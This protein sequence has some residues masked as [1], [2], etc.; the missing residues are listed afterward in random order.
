MWF[1]QFVFCPPCWCRS[2]RHQHG[3]AIHF[4]LKKEFM[5]L[6]ISLQK[7]LF[8][9]QNFLDLWSFTCSL[10]IYTWILLRDVKS[11][12]ILVPRRVTPI[13]KCYT[14]LTKE[15]ELKCQ[16]LCNKNSFWLK[17]WVTKFYALYWVNNIWFHPGHWKFFD[18]VGENQ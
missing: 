5:K 8:W 2:E 16:C 14:F 11:A 3:G 10:Q 7:K 6:L 13:L 12:D 18:D 17:C 4:L 9:A 15:W 1:W